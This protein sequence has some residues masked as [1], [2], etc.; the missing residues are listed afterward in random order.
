MIERASIDLGEVLQDITVP[1]LSLA[2]ADLQ[3][4][5]VRDRQTDLFVEKRRKGW[6]KS[7]EARCDFT[8]RQSLR[9]RA[10]LYFLSLWQKSLYGRT[11]TDIKGDDAMVPYFATEMGNMLQELL[12]EQLSKG[13]WCIITTPK[14]R[15]MVKNF[16]TRI[17]EQI[18]QRLRI[19]FY[20]DVCS[21][22]S[23]QRLNAVFTV[24]LV[25]REQNI[26]CYDDF[27]T[28]GSTLQSMKQ[29]LAPYGKNILM[30][31]SINNKL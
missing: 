11:L 16:A 8:P 30:V 12:G 14:R 29:A 13:D 5:K 19:P 3:S 1:D 2:L 27:V 15:H 22:H 10:G 25:P 18:G 20:E 24:N 7:M 31:S 6:D 17:A 26:I 4:A 21:C 23:K 28:T 9:H